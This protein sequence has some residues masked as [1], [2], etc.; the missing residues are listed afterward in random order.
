MENRFALE[1]KKSKNIFWIVSVF[2]VAFY[3]C[4]SENDSSTK[5]LQKMV[6]TLEG[7]TSEKT[8]FT[9]NGNKIVSIDG[10]HQR[11]D[12]TYTDGLITRIA[13]SNKTTKILETIDYTYLA[14]KLVQVE[15]L[16]K[17]ITKYSHNTDKTI[18]YERFSLGANH[19]KVKEYHGVLTLENGNYT[20]DKRTL[21]NVG[22]G[23]IVKN[24]RTF[25]YDKKINPMSGIIGFDKL[26]NYDE[27]MSSNNSLL[28]VVEDSTTYPN[29]QA[30]SSA[31]M[32]TSI[33]K[34]DTDDYPIEKFSQT[35]LLHSGN[36][37]SLKTEYF[38]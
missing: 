12:F 35:A 31:K 2:T 38:Y 1:M 23:L 17:Y 20:D 28:N 21:D 16:G 7:G 37:G 33:F 3:S 4:L 26:L 15:S 9:Y 10:V 11:S 25:K 36:W 5:L 27:L 24:S 30:T 18:S 6:E 14:G 22:A 29:E 32:H 19:Q 34:Y 8:L 13:V